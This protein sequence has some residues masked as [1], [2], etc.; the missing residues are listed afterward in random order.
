MWSVLR[1]GA[2]IIGAQKSGTTSLAYALGEHPRVSLATNKEAHLFD[3]SDVRA[4]GLDHERM[5]NSFPV[6]SSDSLLLDATPIYMYLP[7]CIEM[8]AEHNP[9]ARIVAILR[10]PGDRA[11]SHYYHSRRNGA[12]TKP[13]LLALL[14]EP[15][16][17]ARDRDALAPLSAHRWWSYRSR[18]KY[19]GQVVRVL[20][21]FDEILLV[22][23]EDLVSDPERVLEKVQEFLG[24]PHVS[25]IQ[26]FDRL[27]YHGPNAAHRF[28]KWA[29]RASLRSE[30]RWM[31]SLLRESTRV[32]GR[33]DLPDLL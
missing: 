32:V 17:L 33:D 9:G 5:M 6:A 19:S 28:V 16:R 21:S 14:L 15:L 27:N 12:E 4:T 29:V 2:A 25:L 23:H 13:L 22:R 24:L 20:E 18:G 10:D 11:V 1:I 30:I 26:A 3:D 8:L 31:R 7:G